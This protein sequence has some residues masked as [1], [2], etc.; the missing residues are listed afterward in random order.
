MVSAIIV[1]MM[2]TCQAIFVKTVTFLKSHVYAARKNYVRSA[3]EL[4]LYV[5]VITGVTGKLERMFASIAE[6]LC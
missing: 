3:E 6:G 5:L 2:F 1:G 4:N